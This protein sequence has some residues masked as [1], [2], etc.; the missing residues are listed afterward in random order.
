MLNKSPTAITPFAD[1]GMQFE[2][3]F[4]KKLIFFWFKI[5]FFNF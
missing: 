1:V 5:I 3:V 4:L 2:I